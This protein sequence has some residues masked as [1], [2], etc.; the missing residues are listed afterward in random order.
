MYKLDGKTLSNDEV[1]DMYY[2]LF[3]YS[4]KSVDKMFEVI[5]DM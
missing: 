3:G 5:R 2:D 4:L 1:T